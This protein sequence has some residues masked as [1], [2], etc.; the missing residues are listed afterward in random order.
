[1]LIKYL[2]ARRVT[3]LD[4]I[5]QPNILLTMLNGDFYKKKMTQYLSWVEHLLCKPVFTVVKGNV[6]SISPKVCP[7]HFVV[8]E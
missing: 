1:M 2:T 3:T 5:N 8:V 6:S 4:L 7:R